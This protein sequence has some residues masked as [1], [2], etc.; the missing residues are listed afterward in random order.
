METGIGPNR[1]QRALDWVLA[2]PLFEGVPY[3]PKL[4]LFAGFAGSLNESLGVGDLVLATDVVDLEGNRWPT[5]WPGE[6]PVGSW[7]PP[8]QAA[9]PF[10]LR[11]N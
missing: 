4:V 2:K 6:L 5:T 7:H 10:Y 11:P 9:A 3:E 8:L 1:A